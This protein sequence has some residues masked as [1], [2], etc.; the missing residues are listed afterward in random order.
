M[1]VPA[2]TLGLLLMLKNLQGPAQLT[3]DGFVLKASTS[4][5]VVENDK[6]GPSKR[7]VKFR[8]YE[9]PS[10]FQL[11]LTQRPLLR[12]CP[13]CHMSFVE[14][15]AQ[16][17]AAHSRHHRNVVAGIPWDSGRGLTRPGKAAGYDVGGTHV[18][19]TKGLR[20]RLFCLNASDAGQRVCDGTLSSPADLIVI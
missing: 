11:H 12:T 9:T 17:E 8:K 16:D 3:L 15:G 13:A 6:P 7:R 19:T 4:A 5:N 1:Y 18:T 20:G 14:G 2:P 10:W